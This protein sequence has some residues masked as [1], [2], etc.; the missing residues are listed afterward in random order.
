MTYADRGGHLFYLYNAKVGDKTLPPALAR[1]P[2]PA[3]EDEEA[4][5]AP[6]TAAYVWDTPVPANN[7]Q[8]AWGELVPLG[9][10]PTIVNPPAGFI[11]ACGTPPWG[12]T[13]NSGIAPASVPLWLA[14]DRDT[15][16]AQRVRHLLSMGPRSF[17]EAQAMVYDVLVPFATVAVPQLVQWADGREQYLQTA[18]PD[19][20]LG[21]E[22]LRSWN[23]VAETGSA[24]MTL[25]NAW[26][27]AYRQL[28]GPNLADV[29]LYQ[30]FVNKPPRVET[31]ALEA[32][33]NAA[34]EMRN[35]HDALDVPWGDV[36]RCA[37]PARG[38]RRRRR[39]RRTAH[40]HGRLRRRTQ[41]TPAGV[42]IRLCHGRPV[43]RHAGIREHHAR[44]HLR[45]SRLAALRRPAHAV[46]RTPVQGELLPR[47]RCAA[48]C[49]T[50]FR[51]A[52]DPPARRDAGRVRHRRPRPRVRAPRNQRDA[53][54]PM[55]DGMAPFTVFVTPVL[56][57][58]SS[59]VTIDAAIYVPPSV[60]EPAGLERLAVCILDPAHG[61]FPAPEQQVNPETRIFR[62]RFEGTPTCAVLG[63]ASL[64]AR[65]EVP[66]APAV[67]ESAPPAPAAAEPAAL[68]TPAE[69]QPPAATAPETASE[70]LAPLPQ[71][72]A[73]GAAPG[74][75]GD[76]ARS[77]LAWG[78]TSRSPSRAAR[79]PAS[80]GGGLARRACERL[81]RA[82]S[83]R[84][85]RAWL[86]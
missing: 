77:A 16:R 57:N 28:A 39:G 20:A 43:R 5:P 50:G 23:F 58:A 1:A 21:L 82:A 4:P 44:R 53:L 45:R 49:G 11:Q 48:L 3:P 52:A 26:W 35:V 59:P 81:R 18:H 62:A 70:A 55:P 32:L 51:A 13:L 86:R 24:G 46:L 36:H 34:R 17:Q 60:V 25:F 12:A 69:P 75:P 31:L 72:P 10:L 64:R 67:A 66:P 27:T 73:D 80:P 9:A 42:R 41:K 68:P 47:Q 38:T 6:Q 63:P 54:A 19:T 40:G 7:P 8:Y 76:A 2:E 84:C 85:P 61:W 15:F 83:R 74:V 33:S 29:V 79:H 22:I 37:R 65:L 78:K 71:T 56:D 14:N 30:E